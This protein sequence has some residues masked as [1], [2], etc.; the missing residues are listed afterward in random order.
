MRVYDPLMEFL[1]KCGLQ[2]VTLTYAE[3]EKIIN[4][5]LPATAYKRREWW[6]NHDRTHSQSAA[7]S[8]VGYETCNI[9]LGTSVTFQKS[10]GYSKHM[11][12]LS[13]LEKCKIL[14]SL[15]SESPVSTGNYYV[16]L[17]KMGNMKYNY[18][19]YLI[20]EPVDCDKELNRLPEAD[21]DLCCALLTMLLRED[22]FSNGSFSRRYKAGD[23]QPVIDRMISLLS[24]ESR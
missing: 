17:E 18:H 4:R 9:L 1:D 6:G 12:H 20:T 19:D 24:E 21:Y 22:H 16:A 10:H 13:N 11:N 3:I 8:D 14:Q 23:V 2:T 5:N 15:K 7:W